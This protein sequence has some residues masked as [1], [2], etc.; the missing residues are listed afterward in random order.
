MSNKGE[1]MSDNAFWVAV[2]GLI[3]AFLLA[4]IVSVTWIVCRHDEKTG[5]H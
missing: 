2:S 1:D 5:S 3:L 4:L